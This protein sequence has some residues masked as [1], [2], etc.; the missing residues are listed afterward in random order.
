[1]RGLGARLSTRE[2]MLIAGFAVFLVA[3]RAAM[4]WHLHVPGH[5][6][7]ATAFGLVLVGSCVERRAA[8]TLCGALAGATCAALGMGEGGPLIALKLLLPGAVVDLCRLGQGG[9]GPASL[10]RGACS[11][12][13]AG[14]STFVPLVAVEWLADVEPQLIALHALVSTGAKVLFGAAG[15]AA[16]AWVAGELRHHGI[17]E[18][19]A[20]SA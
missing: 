4:R 11:G 9:R 13:L 15:G 7:L 18:G 10:L 2:A 17:L 20:T 16:G 6:M 19:R 1:M 8:G 14:A 12:A 5:S 3:A